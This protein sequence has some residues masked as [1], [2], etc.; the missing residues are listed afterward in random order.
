MHFMKSIILL[1]IL[2][3]PFSFAER[4][5][6]CPSEIYCTEEDNINSCK[7]SDVNSGGWSDVFVNPQTNVKIK[8][9]IH[10]FYGTYTNR[11]YQQVIPQRSRVGC[12]YDIPKPDPRVITAFSVSATSTLDLDPI[13]NDSTNW[14]ND[15]PSTPGAHC[16]GDDTKL[17]PFST[18]DLV[19]G[20]TRDK[21]IL[22]PN[23]IVRVY[24]DGK[25]LTYNNYLSI[26]IKNN[27]IL[28]KFWCKNGKTCVF[29]I[30]VT[31]S[32][33]EIGT[34]TADLND[35]LKIINITNNNSRPG[36]RIQQSKHINAVSVT[37]D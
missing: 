1:L 25:F 4:I 3:S 7:I 11:S 14:I 6:Y 30:K 22:P 29:T 37:T 13:Y 12:Y 20:T 15:E 5:I 2:Y 31:E 9:G 32:N 26:G 34:I 27:D 23:K 33:Y 18:P 21:K 10:V 24:M 8:K 17:C 19:I 16:L 28:R 35:S 36:Y